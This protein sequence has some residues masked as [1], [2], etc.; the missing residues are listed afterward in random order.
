MAVQI[1]KPQLLLAIESL[2]FRCQKYHLLNSPGFEDRGNRKKAKNKWRTK[3]VWS[4]SSHKN[5]KINAIIN[6]I[7]AIA[8]SVQY[9]L[10]DQLCVTF[11]TSLKRRECKFL[12]SS[13]YR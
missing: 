11:L 9:E 8:T 7:T 4:I 10:T 13:L 1:W 6:K 3:S 12:A 5:Y 2:P